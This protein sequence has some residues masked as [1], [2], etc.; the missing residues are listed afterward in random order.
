[1]RVPKTTEKNLTW[2]AQ[3]SLTAK[4]QGEFYMMKGVQDQDF[5]PRYLIGQKRIPPF[6]Q[7]LN[8]LESFYVQ[9]RSTGLMTSAQQRPY[10]IFAVYKDNI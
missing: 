10:P 2:I 9:A 1:M 4:I 8:S 7:L 6:F 3:L 5:A